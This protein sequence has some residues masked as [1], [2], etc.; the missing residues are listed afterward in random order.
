LERVGGAERQPVPAPQATGT[1]AVLW[2]A[3]VTQLGDFELKVRSST[4][5]THVKKLSVQAAR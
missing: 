1:S 4:G 5:V 3:R 2:K